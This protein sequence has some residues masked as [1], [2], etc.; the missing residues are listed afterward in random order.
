MSEEKTKPQRRRNLRQTIEGMAM[1]FNAEAAGD[2]KATIQFDVSGEEPGI[3]HLNIDSG[4]CLFRTGACSNPIL[5]VKTPSEV[6][7]QVS[8]KQISG[9]DA[10][11]QGLYTT[12]GD[13]RLLLKFNSLFTVPDNINVTEISEPPKMLFDIFRRGQSEAN[14]SVSAGR[15]PAGPLSLNGMTWLSFFFVPWTLFWVLF[16]IT[17]IDIWISTGIPFSLM[18]LIVIYRIVFNRPVWTELASWL[19]FLAA[20]FLA[21]IAHE[22]TFLAWGSV[23]ASLFMAAMWLISLSPLVP[24]PFCAE[25]SKW[26]FIKKLWRNSMFIEPNMAISL[27]WGWTI[28]VSSGFGIAAKL[29]PAFYLLFTIIR[30]AFMVPAFLFTR[31]YQKG[32]QDRQFADID[33]RIAKQRAWA[34]AGFAVTVIVALVVWFGLKPV[35]F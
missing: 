14:Q 23:I 24:L 2:L 5:T 32:T 10:L 20:I 35:E 8:R 22:P 19:F 3:Y 25:Y 9:Q 6:W 34:Y 13:T 18:S 16:N 28:I 29:L 26:G 27:F 1:F 21:P 4:D 17:G 15:C 31:Y 12:K 33:R 7:L 30:Y 11:F